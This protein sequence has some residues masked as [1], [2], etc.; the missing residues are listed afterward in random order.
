ME[1]FQ[2]LIYSGSDNRKSP[3]DLY[4]TENS[5]DKPLVIFAHGYK[6][7]K[8]WGAWDLV[9]H[10]FAEAGFDF[11]KFNFSHNGGTVENPIDYPDMEAYSEN[12]YSK[13]LYDIDSLIKLANSGIQV[14]GK[15]KTWKN[16]ALIGHSRG[17]GIVILESARNASVSHLSTWASVADY[18]ERFNFDMEEWKKTGVATVLNGRTKQQMPHKYSFYQ[19]FIDNEEKLNIESAARKINI[20]WL[21]VHGDSDEAVDFEEA[22][23]LH[24][25]S[26]DA[27]VV[28]IPDGMHTFGASHPWNEMEMPKP[29]KKVVDET[30]RFFALNH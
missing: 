26:Q 21:I 2:N 10:A 17:G 12:T 24:S 7:F 23:R 13:E 15:M 27:E 30:I 6:G 11:L 20:P 16:I 5:A 18:G 22:E 28:Q 14:N 1:I 4:L 9:A 19:D 25:W 3:F 8:D 29:L